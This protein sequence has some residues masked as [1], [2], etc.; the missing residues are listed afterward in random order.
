MGSIEGHWDA[1]FNNI[2]QLKYNAV[3]FAPL[4]KYGYSMSHY[5]IADQLIIDDFFFKNPYGE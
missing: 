4:Q 1:M 5:S 3:H 2:A